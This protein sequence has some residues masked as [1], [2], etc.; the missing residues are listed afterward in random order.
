MTITGSYDI[1]IVGGG[2]GGLALGY[3]LANKYSVLVIEARPRIVPSKRGL[4]LQANGLEALQKLDLL[5]RVA[6]LG[7]KTSHVA[8]YEIGGNLLAD[9]DYSILDHPYGY[10]LT[11][12]PSELERVLRDQFSRRGGEIQESTSFR[13]AVLHHD[14]VRLRVQRNTSSLE[15]CKYHCRCGRGKLKGKK[16][17]EF[18]NTDQRMSRS[19][20]LYARKALGYVTRKSEAVLC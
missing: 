12:I 5:E 16:W 10:I 1:V 11:L 7:V 9:L 6:P 18:A 17:I 2:V 20:P 4:S 3:A 19:L 15:Y 13:E 8:W 14:N